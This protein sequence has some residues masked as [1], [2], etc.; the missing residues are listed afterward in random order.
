MYILCN[1]DNDVLSGLI[2]DFYVEMKDYILNTSNEA[3]VGDLYG[4]SDDCHYDTLLDIELLL[5]TLIM[6]YNEKQQDILN[7]LEYEDSHYEDEYN[8]T[9]MRKYF[10][11]KDIRISDAWK[12]F[13]PVLN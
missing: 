10:R 2:E 3:Y 7:G 9:C 6:A 11:C 4:T 12:I 1:F 8:L 5:G 13:F